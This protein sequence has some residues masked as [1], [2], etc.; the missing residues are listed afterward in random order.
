M[1]SSNPL[2]A[3][4]SPLC[5]CGSETKA[6]PIHECCSMLPIG[7]SQYRGQIQDPDAE[8]LTSPDSLGPTHIVPPETLQADLGRAAQKS[9]DR[10]LQRQFKCIHPGYNRQFRHR[11]AL[12]RHLICHSDERLY[13]CWVPE[14]YC[15]FK[16]FDNLLAH[17][18]THS[19]LN[20]R[21]RYIATLDKVCYIYD[22]EFC[23]T[24]TPQG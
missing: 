22:P 2:S 12:E 14:C 1:Q 17:Y 21:N 3:L 15:T 5:A 6:A 24:L 20:G 16:H 19:K 10:I 9:P 23:G 18:P 11:A 8:A 13:V 4:N 7:F